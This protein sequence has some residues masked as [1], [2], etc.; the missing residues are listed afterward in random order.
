L[1]A[2]R[3]HSRHRVIGR[4]RLAAALQTQLCQFAIGLFERR[5]YPGVSNVEQACD[6]DCG[7]GCSRRIE[8]LRSTGARSR[9][10]AGAYLEAR[11]S[12]LHSGLQ[13]TPLELALDRFF[14]MAIAHGL[15]LDLHVN[16]SCSAI[17][18]LR[19]PF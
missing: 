19:N 17:S 1:A 11:I 4:R 16:E 2:V 5:P 13:L 10:D 18:S 14:G 6:R 15:D 7:A 3:L 12:T 9:E 8:R